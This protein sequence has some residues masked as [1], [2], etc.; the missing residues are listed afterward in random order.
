[1]FA[2]L[3][4]TF[5][6]LLGFLLIVIFIWYLGPYFAFG[7]YRPLETQT[8]RLIAIAVIV[9]CWLLA[10]LV[11]RLRAYRA[12]DRLLAAV[13]AQPQPEKARPP[14]EVQKLR[15]RFDEAVAALKQQR[16]SGHSLYELPW[17]VIIGAPGSGKT[18]ALLNSGLK[19]PIAQRVGKEALKGV[20]GTRNCDWWFTDE[21][22]FLDTAGRYTT[23]DSDATSDSVGWSEFLA[24]LRKYRA[25]RPVN[26]VILTINAQDLIV[27]GAAAR[28]AHVEAARA[29]LE[30]LNRE[31][32]IQLPVYLMVTKCDLVDGFAE[33][34]DDLTAESRAQVWGVTFPYDQTLANEGPQVFPS[35]F[36]ALMSRLNERVFE[37]IEAVRDTRRRTKVFAF[38]QQMATLRDALTQFVTDVFAS[39]EF[40]GQ[41]LLRGVYFTSGTQH[42]N[43]IDRLLGSIGRRFGASAGVMAPS[44]PGKAYFVET[45]LKDVMI[46]ESGLAGINRRLE[47][48][49]AAAQ[50]G[51]YAAVGLVAAS[52]V[53]VLSVSYNRNREFLEQIAPDIAAYDQVA[54][55]SRADSLAEIVP[56]LDAVRAIVDT[57]DRYRANTTWAMSW[58]L[59]QGASI[60]NAAQNA[61]LHELDGMLLPRVA[62][63]IR[64]R[65]IQFASEP[66]KLYLYLKGYL[67]LGE[68]KH[69]DKGHLK[70]LTDLEWEAAPSGVGPALSK[71]FQSLLDSSDRLR[72][73]PLDS[74]LVSQAR[75]SIRQ[76]SMSKIMYDGVK[77]SYTAE[78]AAG[79]RVNELAGL[80]VEKVFKR[81]SGVPLSSPIPKLYTR[82]AFKEITGSG[83]AELLVQMNRD[84]WVWGEN[85]ATS[86]AN[87]RSLVSG[88]TNLYEQD[89]IR[90]WEALLDDLQ[91][92]SF[93]SVPQLNDALR[94]LTAPSSPLRG[95]L[96]V[97]RDNT[98]LVETK[99]PSAATGVIDQT[100]KRFSDT[101]SG[102]L[103]PLKGMMNQPSVAPGMLVT[104]QFQWVRQLTAGEAGKTQLDAIIGTLSEIQQQLDTLGPDVS[105]ANPV[106]IMLGPSFRALNQRLRDQTDALPPGIRKLLSEIAVT[107]G[108]VVTHE[109]TSE[110]EHLYDQQV[111]PTCRASIANR[112]PFANIAQPDVQ[113]SDFGAVF[114]YDGLFDKFFNA[115]LEKQVDTSQSPWAWRP[116]AVNPARS[117]LA[118][119]QA[120]RRLRDMFFSPGSKMPEVKF[121]VTMRDLDSNS[122]RFVLEIDGQTLDE[123]HQAPV[124]KLAVW[125]GP[126]PGR[127]AGTFEGNFYENPKQYGGPWAWF[128]MIDA[129]A[130][131]PGDA[132]QRIRLIVQNRYHRVNVT[133]QAS[134]AGDNPF[135]TRDWRQF[136]CES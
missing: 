109:A 51:A 117:L 11:R 93:Q 112:Y 71:H 55:T 19:L 54:R 64:A 22:I 9:G 37:R 34:F 119:F 36:D 123:K 59:Y 121:G 49:K 53:A 134:R 87:A 86:L 7:D 78:N 18:T 1:M 90:E 99:S 2:F 35:E 68:P 77:R 101:L 92:A 65:M 24:L 57:A 80:G 83:Q 76:T 40:D 113:L 106:G 118:Q 130:D 110:I 88:V 91:F 132:Q 69:L 116:G 108:E 52:G 107:P 73:L 63:Q 3:K 104:S 8:A 115:N 41:V 114:G 46:G 45:L 47:A 136:S 67:M 26:G 16:R 133:V 82:E 30:E 21:A 103:K 31:L 70:L 61:Y 42:G 98:A 72:P 81:R 32:R 50:L 29:R 15:E 135:A 124:T 111:V 102:V 48:R 10:R 66:E 13:V 33:Y 100:T 4:R 129:L 44:G 14:A 12:S 38:P 39:R 62:A 131:G 122:T 97:V 105:G 95:I 43:P 28:E 58:G 84:A 94:I 126:T 20:G 85:A 79:L 25:R 60:G 128:R 96:N 56:R 89:Y 125:P 27:Q 127:A 120:A 6:I 17:Y 74:T 75:S 23:Q 5:V